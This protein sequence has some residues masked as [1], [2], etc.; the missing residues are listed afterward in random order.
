VVD[1]AQRDWLRSVLI[2]FQ[3]GEI[4]RAALAH[5]LARSCGDPAVF[6][7]CLELPLLTCRLDDIPPGMEGRSISPDEWNVLVLRCLLF[8]RTDLPYEWRREYI[9]YLTPGEALLKMGSWWHGA[10][11]L[12]V[13]WSRHVRED[14][15]RRLKAEGDPDVWPFIRWKDYQA[16]LLRFGKDEW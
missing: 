11:E 3:R 9:P 7:I 10:R 15:R 14:H 13:D 5:E 8:L 12:L 1:R 16:A 6:H 2:A 4:D